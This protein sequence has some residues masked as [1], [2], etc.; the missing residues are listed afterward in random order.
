MKMTKPQQ[1]KLIKSI[2]KKEE[3]TRD[4]AAYLI[5]TGLNMTVKL[6]CEKSGMSFRYLNEALTFIRPFNKELQTHVLKVCNEL[7]KIA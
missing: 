5:K 3:I 6:F 2:L 4:E 1:K 7:I